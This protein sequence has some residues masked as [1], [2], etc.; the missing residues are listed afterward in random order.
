MTINYFLVFQKT[1]LIIFFSVLETY[2]ELKSLGRWPAVE[3]ALMQGPESKEWN[4]PHGKPKE[5]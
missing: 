3:G 4:N 1:A 5:N 2:Q